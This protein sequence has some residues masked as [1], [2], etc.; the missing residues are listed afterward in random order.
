MIQQV[1]HYSVSPSKRVIMRPKQ[2]REVVAQFDKATMK[3]KRSP[4]GST[5]ALTS[6]TAEQPFEETLG[7]VRV[8]RSSQDGSIP[9]PL[10]LVIAKAE[11]VT[12]CHQQTCLFTISV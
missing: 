7:C 9:V 10:D 12:Y 5:H 6:N 4:P 11:L 8:R 1:L 2:H 3:S